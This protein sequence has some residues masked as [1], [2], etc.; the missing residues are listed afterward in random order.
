MLQYQQMV[1]EGRVILEFQWAPTLGGEC[2]A[3]RLYPKTIATHGEL[4]WAPTLGGECYLVEALKSLV[5][6][7]NEFQWAPTLGGECY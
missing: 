7:T 5:G 4:Q 3:G 1:S 2:Y 6:V